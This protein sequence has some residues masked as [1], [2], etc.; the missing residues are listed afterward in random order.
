MLLAAAFLSVAQAPAAAE[1][2]WYFSLAGDIGDL[3]A[4]YTDRASIR[5]SGDL[6]SV[7]EARE[8]ERADE[9]NIIGSRL[10][11]RYDCRARTSQ[12]LRYTFVLTDGSRRVAQRAQDRPVPAE[13]DSIAAKG[14]GIACGESEGLEQLGTLGI[15][16]QALLL[17]AERTAYVRAHPEENR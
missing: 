1:D 9:Q 2:W 17:F 15:R 4:F 6:V 3:A 10:L 13:P 11:V 12:V 14:L 7:E 16:E 5:R 8:G